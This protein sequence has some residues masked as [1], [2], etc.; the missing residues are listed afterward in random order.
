MKKLVSFL[1]VLGLFIGG[2]G[3]AQA[4]TIQWYEPFP[5]TPITGIEAYISGGTFEG[6]MYNFAA[7][8]SGGTTPV[9]SDWSSFVAL[10]YP[11][12]TAVA[13]SGSA[14]S[15]VGFWLDFIGDDV[16]IDFFSMS[17]G[18]NVVFAESYNF[19]NGAYQAANATPVLPTLA[20]NAAPVPEPATMLLFGLG[21]LGLAGVSRKKK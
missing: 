9:L 19:L 15:V 2:S 4:Y 14:S 10:N 1:M 21:L 3:L 5:A 7:T 20:P 6:P 18:R 8:N 17:T 11:A 12:N 16:T 13:A